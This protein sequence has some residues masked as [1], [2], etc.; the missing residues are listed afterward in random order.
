MGRKPPQSSNRFFTLV[1]DAHYRFILNPG[2]NVATA[3]NT[4]MEQATFGSPFCEG[5]HS[6][7]FFWVRQFFQHTYLLANLISYYVAETDAFQSGKSLNFAFK[8]FV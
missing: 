8:T 5:R 6:F 2:I 4:T 1:F 3:A 7:C